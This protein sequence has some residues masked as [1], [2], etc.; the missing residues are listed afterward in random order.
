ML[1]RLFLKRHI[2]MLKYPKYMKNNNTKEKSSNTGNYKL[3]HMID[4]TLQQIV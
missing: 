4:N 1:D 2:K 3:N